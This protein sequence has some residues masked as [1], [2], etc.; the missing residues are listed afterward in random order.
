[1]RPGLDGDGEAENRRDGDPDSPTPQFA[2]SPAWGLIGRENEVALLQEAIARGRLHHAYLFCGPP[3]AGKTALALALAQTLNCHVRAQAGF[4]AEEKPGPCGQCSAC[5]RIGNA[6]HPDVTTI[7]MEPNQRE[8]GID[9]IRDDVTHFANVKLFEGGW[10]VFII[11]DADRMTR[12]AANALLKTLEEPPPQTVLVLNTAAEERVLPTI[13]SRCQT[14]QLQ[15]VPAAV[16]AEALAERFGLNEEDALAIASYAQGAPGTAFQ[17]A[18]DP[19]LL[20]TQTGA[21]ERLKGLL[22]AALPERLDAAGNLG[23]VGQAPSPVPGGGVRNATIDL[24]SRWE[25][26]WRDLLLVHQG[27]TQGLVYAGEQDTYQ[28]YAKALTLPQ[29]RGGLAAVQ[30]A[31]RQLQANAIPR[32]VLDVLVLELPAV[33]IPE[34]AHAPE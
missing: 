34:R 15:R 33:S 22:E 17:A 29:V 8:L 3:G 2:G 10:R 16:L 26:W 7:A 31:R 18:E 32:L 1:V 21:L 25:T 6:N 13:R 27:C 5:R 23:D 11:Q 19:S 28:T 14:I 9:V 12:E 24:L 4:F 30:T 20:E